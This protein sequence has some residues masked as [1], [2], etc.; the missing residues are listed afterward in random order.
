MNKKPAYRLEDFCDRAGI[1][2]SAFF[3]LANQGIAPETFTVGMQVMVAH[4]E[5]ADE[6]IAEWQERE[7]CAGNICTLTQGDYP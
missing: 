7:I 3:D 6:W 2:L 1:P 4:D 5:A